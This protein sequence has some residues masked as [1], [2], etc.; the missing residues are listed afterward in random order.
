MSGEKP[1]IRRFCKVAY[2]QACLVT[3]YK[4]NNNSTSNVIECVAVDRNRDYHRFRSLEGDGPYSRHG[5]HA[6]CSDR[7]RKEGSF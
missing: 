1:D 5:K 3:D 7:S 4:K 2:G 6:K